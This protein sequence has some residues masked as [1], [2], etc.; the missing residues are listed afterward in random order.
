MS[1]TPSRVMSEGAPLLGT[2]SGREPYPL[3]S[4]AT[5]CVVLGLA[6][7][8]AVS[9]C[10]AVVTIE[11]AQSSGLSQISVKEVY[12]RSETSV[13]HNPVFYGTCAVVIPSDTYGGGSLGGAIDS[14]DC[15][16]R[17]NGHGP[18]NCTT[19]SSSNEKSNAKSCPSPEDY[20][21]KDDIRVM[22]GNPEMMDNLDFDACFGDGEG[23]CQR[24]IV[25]WMDD[26]ERSRRFFAEHPN[27]E[28]MDA[29]IEKL[30]IPDP[31]G[32]I[33]GFAW[34]QSVPRPGYASSAFI[35]I[36]V[37]KDPRICGQLYVFGLNTLD[38]SEPANHG[39]ADDPHKST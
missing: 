8:F 14:A 25:T 24:Q 32:L 1:V 27:A 30:E 7:L 19:D 5:R 35:T 18:G 2:G 11:R 9:A 33:R 28:S 13:R 4:R 36:N 10:T 6:A 31:H 17:F 12:A 34:N 16:V 22:N 20:G 29:L 26:T 21:T 23:H 37:L 39:Y 38:D 3:A 15:V